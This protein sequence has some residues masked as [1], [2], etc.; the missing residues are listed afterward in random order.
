MVFF[1]SYCVHVWR[2][3][4][5]FHFNA[6]VL[7]ILRGEGFLVIIKRTYVI[8]F[9]KIVI[10]FV[11]I[12]IDSV[13]CYGTSDGSL[14]LTVSGGTPVFTYSWEHSE[15]GTTYNGSNIVGLSGGT[16]YVTVQ[17]A[18]GCIEDGWSYD[19]YEPDMMQFNTVYN[20][21][22]S[23]LAKYGWSTRLLEDTEVERIVSKV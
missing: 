7:L 20:Y 9:E 11:I 12:Y 10:T 4:L 13:K 23:L 15:S 18:N 5:V 2:L 17:D 22:N 16:Y 6:V 19:V 3:C 21:S 14:E 1:R 8:I